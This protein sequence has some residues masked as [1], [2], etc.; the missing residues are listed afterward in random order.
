MMRQN[1]RHQTLSTDSVD[2]CIR[3]AIRSITSEARECLLLRTRDK[4]DYPDIARR[5]GVSEQVAI[6]HVHRTRRFL[7]HRFAEMLAKTNNGNEF[8]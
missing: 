4:L 1:P 2:E 3:R 6:D 8:P 7:R 5:V